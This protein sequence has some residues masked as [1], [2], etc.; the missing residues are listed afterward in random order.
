MKNNSIFNPLLL[1]IGITS[2]S[3]VH[4]H[5][6]HFVFVCKD[7]YSILVYG[8]L[9]PFILFILEKDKTVIPKSLKIVGLFLSFLFASFIAI[10]NNY[11]YFYN[12]SDC[13]GS[14]KAILLLLLQGCLYTTVFYRII[15]WVL[16]KFETFTLEYDTRKLNLRKW[17][18]YI[19]S[20]KFVFFILLFPCLFDFDAALGVR[21]FLDSN[22][23][24]CN[25]HPVCVE[26]IHAL[27]FCFGKIVGNPTFGFSL[28]S[29]CFIL[30][31]TLI[32]LYGINII[33]K[34]HIS[35]K[36]QKNYAI[37]MSFFPFFPALS[38]LPTKDGLFAYS[39]LLYVLSVFDIFLSNGAC[40]KQI[41]YFL[42]YSF[43]AL[44]VCLTRHQ[45]ISI[46]L[47]TSLGLCLYIKKRIRT[48]SV[49]SPSIVIALFVTQILFPYL[50]IEDGG[51]Q[52]M[53]GTLFQQTA[54]YLRL[55]PNDITSKESNA[56]D[57][58]LNVKTIANRYKIH[59]TD[60]VKNEYKY[61]PRYIESNAGPR[62][63]RH[64]NHYNEKKDL[65]N[66]LFAWTTMGVRHPS[67]YFQATGA[68]TLGFFYNTNKALFDIFSEGFYH[69][70]ANTEKYYFWKIDYF[71]Q[72]YYGWRKTLA[73]TPI[74]NLITAI[75]YYIWASIVLL[76]LLCY[77]KDIQGIIIFLPVFLSIGILLICPVINGRYI[78]PIVVL[79]PL[80]FIYCLLHNCE[81]NK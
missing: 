10:G 80:L 1:G 74:L 12:W 52:E 72:I 5:S 9:I 20:I 54:N 56:I 66:Y 11:Y 71:Y 55:Y 3:F 26:A 70:M 15:N 39:L 29:I 8:G 65:K 34:T 28:L 50:N 67:A 44:S 49:V 14:V 30:I 47:I 13:F 69:P 23:A 73:S 32:E 17:F 37:V 33:G 19:I 36:W 35:Y 22:S 81:K 76:S 6:G 18:L 42:L 64:V 2:I 51:K 41:K 62:K 4:F 59:V 79:L 58:I 16:Q 7:I 31:T 53:Y 27:F 43:A 78:F 63:F 40:M 25:H 46:I 77:R 75:P 60:P 48:I 24:I 21:T 38:L 57:V 45:G 68:I 61:N